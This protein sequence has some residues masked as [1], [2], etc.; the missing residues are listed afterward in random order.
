MET[1]ELGAGYNP[2]PDEEATATFKGNV[3]LNLKVEDEF[4]KYFTNE[5]I[6]N[7]IASHI[8]DYLEEKEIIDVDI[9]RMEE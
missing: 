5:D 6:K 2:A 8:Y 9:Y 3:I 1:S 4:P 7:Y